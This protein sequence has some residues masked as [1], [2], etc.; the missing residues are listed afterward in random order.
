ML[1]EEAR[2]DLI[3]P[4]I[5]G[6]SPD[7]AGHVRSEVRAGTVLTV[8]LPEQSIDVILKM[9]DLTLVDARQ[10]QRLG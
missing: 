4:K 2:F 8:E 7:V 3:F 10:F 9:G 6:Q 1:I 5:I